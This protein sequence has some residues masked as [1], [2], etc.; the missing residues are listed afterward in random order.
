DPLLTN[1]REQL[2]VP[3]APTAIVP[4]VFASPDYVATE[5]PPP[6]PWTPVSIVCTGYDP[7]VLDANLFGTPVTRTV[8]QN[9]VP[10]GQTVPVA[11]PP[12]LPPTA[13]GISVICTA[14][15]QA[16]S[17]TLVKNVVNNVRAPDATPDMWLLAADSGGTH[18]DFGPGT[19]D[20]V[21]HLVATGT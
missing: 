13:N 12:F 20:G 10:T 21:T 8:S 7:L 4:G 11:P 17:I 5:D 6:A 14:T 15:N 2:T 1:I 9:G 18:V 16:P 3:T 19:S